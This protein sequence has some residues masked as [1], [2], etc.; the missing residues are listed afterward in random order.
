MK[1]G[2]GRVENARPNLFMDEEKKIRVYLSV[3]MHRRTN[4]QIEYEI[5]M[6][7][8]FYLSAYPENHNKVIFVH[9]FKPDTGDRNPAVSHR[10]RLYFLGEA[11]QKLSTCDVAIFHPNWRESHGC[12]IEKEACKLFNIITVCETW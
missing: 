7:K 11:L 5:I 1:G 4:K 10:D 6:M 2:K 8:A 12:Q 3:P 9:N